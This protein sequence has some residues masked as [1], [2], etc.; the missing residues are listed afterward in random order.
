MFEQLIESGHRSRRGWSPSATAVGVH[1]T[2]LVL[3]VNSVRNRPPETAI[4][5]PYEVIM[6]LPA[7]DSPVEA[8]AR[9]T[10]GGT[11]VEPA[12]EPGPITSGPV[13][14]PIVEGPAFPTDSAVSLN[15]LARRLAGPG[16]TTSRAVDWF[17]VV[18]HDSLRA[19]TPPQPLLLAD[20]VYPPSLKAAGVEGGVTIEYI[21]GTNGLADSA[22]I[23]V[24]A[25][26]FEAFGKAAAGAVLR[27]QYRPGS[28]NG[29]PV[30]VRVRQMVRFLVK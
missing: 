29:H 12:P 7:T 24:I 13:T 22:S 9:T 15:A 1:A 17:G 30:A 16:P 25:A 4:V 11:V 18:G 21:V 14:V 10:G 19:G 5:P 23:R 6:E 26:D 27:S 3:A 28:T 8:G 20:P 2:L